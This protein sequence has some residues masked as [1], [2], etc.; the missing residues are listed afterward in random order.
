MP[1]VY[2]IDKAEPSAFSL[3]YLR[4]SIFFTVGLTELLEQKEVEAVLLHEL[5]HI[6]QRSSFVKFT[7]TFIRLFVPI[8]NFNPLSSELGQ[9]EHDADVIAIM[10]QKTDIH[11]RHAKE[12][13]ASYYAEEEKRRD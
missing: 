9:E 2:L 12:K 6:K 10:L 7:N 3:S 11:I 4:P 5:G 1:R 13:I 8:A